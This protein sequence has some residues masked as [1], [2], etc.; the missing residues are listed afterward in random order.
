MVVNVLNAI[1]VRLKT[2]ISTSLH[3]LMSEK[4]RSNS[5]RMSEIR[6]F[7]RKHLIDVTNK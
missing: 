1:S 2:A 5:E 4:E 3:N 6:T 7:A